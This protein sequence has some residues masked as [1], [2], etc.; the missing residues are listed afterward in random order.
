MKLLAKKKT[1]MRIS[2]EGLLGRIADG[3]R[4]DKGQRFG[5][6]EMLDNM[7][8]M[9]NEFYKGNVSMVDEFCQL[10]CF[11]EE[12]RKEREKQETSHD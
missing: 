5:V 12:A 6:R 10:Y 2:G 9:A 3:Q 8:L 1:N 7:E 4:P 11:G